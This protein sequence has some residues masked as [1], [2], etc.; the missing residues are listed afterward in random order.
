[1]ARKLH[2]RLV[3]EGT[4]VT[5]SP[6]HV[7]GYG[8]SADTDLPIA[9]NGANKPYL[10]GT[11]IAGVLRAWCEQSFGEKTTNE[12][13]GPKIKKGT[14]DDGHASFILIE[15][16][17]VALSSDADIE[18][19]DGVG[20]DRVSGAAAEG[21]KYDRA[22]IPRGARISLRM[23]VEIKARRQD[24]KDESRNETDESFQERYR[25]I[26][27]IIGHMLSALEA[28]KIMFGAAR[29]R[30]LGRTGFE[31][32]SIKRQTLNNRHGMLE[33]LQD[34]GA[35]IDIADLIRSDPSIEFRPRQRLGIEIEWQPVG[36]LMVKA[37]YE[38][39][40]VDMLPMVSRTEQ[41]VRL[42][43]P[44]SSIKGSLRNQAERIVRTVREL[45]ASR[46]ENSRQRFLNQ[47][48]ELPLIRELFGS[49]AQS[50][51]D[52]KT[53]GDDDEH[54]TNT[55]IKEPLPGLGALSVVDCYAA[56]LIPADLWHEVEIA[57]NDQTVSSSERELWGAIKKIHD[58][59]DDKLALTQ[60]HHVAIDRWTG[61]AAE[62]MLF[63]VLAPSKA[64]WE[65]IRLSIDFER[66]PSNLRLPALTLVLLTLRD[67]MQKR[68]SLGFATN[69]G[70]GEIEVSRIHLQGEELHSIG[71]SMSAGLEL[72][73]DGLLNVEADLRK[74]LTD[75]WTEWAHKV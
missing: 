75:A 71:L 48:D 11:S 21:M 63:S 39:I 2:S 64:E 5:I 35:S 51:P 65:P 34:G 18:I 73:G 54:T 72:K 44:G 14:S 59:S 32:I 60:S 1:M 12:I 9:R 20:I 57:T 62:G 4:L 43:L 8:E 56:Q 50:K 68:I 33:A 36:P 17:P 30:G 69:R 45:D 47:L 3:V 55:A 40:G 24:Q 28:G 70:M 52:R 29:T 23:Q 58:A 10:P 19:R 15:D 49:R 37:G 22:I 41:G 42:V 25:R 53:N 6:L 31:L 38:G 46:T 61:G 67:L 66:L 16:A 27:S 7:G 13:W 74:R 26:K